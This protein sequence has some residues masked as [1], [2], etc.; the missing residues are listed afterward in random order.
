MFTAT[1]LPH[2]RSFANITASV[3][4]VPYAIFAIYVHFRYLLTHVI[5]VRVASGSNIR[6]FQVPFGYLLLLVLGWHA[7]PTYVHFK[8]ISCS[9]F[10]LA[11][12][13]VWIPCKCWARS[14]PSFV[15]RFERAQRLLCMVSRRF[16]APDG[17]DRTLLLPLLAPSHEAQTF[18]A[19]SVHACCMEPR[20]ILTR[21]TC[22]CQ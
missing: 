16:V 6:T 18:R 14:N 20:A 10:H 7:A 8:L 1:V 2:K 3:K 21:M 22:L 15:Q 11:Q 9:T 12:R 17:I 19:A 5:L 13:S 4:C